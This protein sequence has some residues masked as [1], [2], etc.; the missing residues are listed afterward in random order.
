MYGRNL[1]YLD[2]RPLEAKK[3]HSHRYTDDFV[4]MDTNIPNVLSHTKPTSKT[5]WA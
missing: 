3:S 2:I 5:F 1:G 4:Q